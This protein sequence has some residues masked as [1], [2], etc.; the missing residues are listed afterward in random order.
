M[1]KVLLSYLS[2]L[3]T[4]DEELMSLLC[5]VATCLE[6]LVVLYSELFVVQ[7]QEEAVQGQVSGQAQRH[8]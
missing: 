1:V 6:R 4:S 8:L 2:V 3:T 7:S 5:V